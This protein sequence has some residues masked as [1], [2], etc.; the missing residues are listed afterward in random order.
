MLS[1]L[2]TILNPK[3][4]T[5]EEL[6]QLYCCPITTRLMREPV[7]TS[8]GHTYEREAIEAWLENHDT[9]PMGSEPLESKKLT[10]VLLATKA[11]GSLLEKYSELKDPKEWYLPES[12]IKA[13]GRAC[14]D[15]DEAA[16]RELVGRD[17]R[18]LE[19]TFDNKSVHGGKTALQL[20]VISKQR[21]ALEVVVQLLEQRQPGLSLAALLRTNAQ[22]LAPLH[23]A[24]LAERDC[25]TLLQI[26]NWMSQGLNTIVAPQDW[27]LTEHSFAAH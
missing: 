13:L 3:P 17:R 8:D 7:T 1:D 20:A 14:E 12:W 4:F 22:G 5:Q 26:M 18:L 2:E 11:V 23:L 6:L 25:E 15:G 16:I 27:P 19:H 10:P 21:K 9:S 24:I